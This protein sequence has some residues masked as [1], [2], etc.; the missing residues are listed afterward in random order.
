MGVVLKVVLKKHEV[1]GTVG[2][3]MFP[4]LH[5]PHSVMDLLIEKL[6]T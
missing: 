2:I 6:Y 4:L 5:C 3:I 1:E